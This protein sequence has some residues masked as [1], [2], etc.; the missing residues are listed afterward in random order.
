MQTVTAL[1]LML[2][3][4]RSGGADGW[5]GRWSLSPGGQEPGKMKV[6]IYGGT[7]N[8]SALSTVESDFTATLM[9]ACSLPGT[10]QATRDGS[11]VG[12]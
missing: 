7:H 5:C 1:K 3:S 8:Y 11:C 12:I 9:Y 4:L 2:S 10:H 6:T